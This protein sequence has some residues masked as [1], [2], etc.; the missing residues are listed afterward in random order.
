MDS[1]AK[2]LQQ[3][4]ASQ[5]APGIQWKSVLVTAAVTL[6]VTFVAQMG[7][8]YF[9]SRDPLLV[10]DTT[11]SIPFYGEKGLVGIYQVTLKNEGKRLAEDVICPIKIPGGK[12]EQYRVSADASQ[13]V[14]QET[15]GDSLRL[16]LPSLNPS[17][18]LSV[19]LLASS[20]NGLPPSPEVAFRAKGFQGA[21]KSETAG[22]SQ[23]ALEIASI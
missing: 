1:N 10:Y 4:G 5:P 23:S 16:Q 13:T 9:Q 11:Q 14:G 22:D 15:S 18:M 8:S 12:I 3:E 6:L 19:S 21:K 20:T 2:N 17:E 7:V